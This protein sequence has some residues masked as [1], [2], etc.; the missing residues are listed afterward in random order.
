[1]KI[2]ML[3]T[4]G[5]T[6]TKSRGLPSVAI[7]REGKVYLFDC[8]EGTQMKM[9]QH[10][11]NISSIKAIFISHIHGDH[12]IGLAGLVRT[13]ALN[14]RKDPLIIFVPS[15]YE[16]A[17][18][19]LITFDKALIKYP[20]TITGVGRGKIYEEE[21]IEVKAFALNHTVKSIGYVFKEKK[22]MRFIKEKCNA[23]G[24]KGEEFSII[25]KEG[26]IAKNGKIIKLVEVT[27]A[28]EGKKVVYATDTRP[29]ASTVRASMNAELLIHE[30]TFT[31]KEKRLAVERK[32][33]TAREAALIAK[34]AE[35][36]MLIL[37][38]I[39]ARYR[40]TIPLISE[41]KKIFYNVKVAKDGMVVEI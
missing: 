21:D 16:G 26:C 18:K 19:K 39:S 28:K 32:H 20:I 13:L 8:G 37:T 35:V 34:K 12:V 30:A 15:G 6:P 9:M 10:G 4:S 7:V 31:E 14:N 40:N 1:M 17:V 33:T 3:G 27:Y 29:C 36:R 24:I 25:S 23:L 22:K 41:A 2:V 38:H 5:S 11:V